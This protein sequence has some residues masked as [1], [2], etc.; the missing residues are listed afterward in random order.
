MSK[1][2]SKTYIKVCCFHSLQAAERTTT[3]LGASA[4]VQEQQRSIIIYKGVYLAPILL[5]HSISDVKE[6]CL[7]TLFEAPDA[8]SIYVWRALHCGR[9]Y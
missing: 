3:P 6:R 2:S 8:T 5:H 1:I 4:Q 9:K 7:K